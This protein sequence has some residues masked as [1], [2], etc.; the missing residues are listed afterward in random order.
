[1]KNRSSIKRGAWIV[2]L[3]AAVSAFGACHEATYVVDPGWDNRVGPFRLSFSLD[4][5][6]Q[7]THGGH[8]IHIAVVR[9]GVVVAQT[10]GTVSATQNPSFSFAAGA[11]L[12]QGI[13]HEVHYWIDSNIGGGTPGVCDPKAIDHQWS[14]EFSWPTNDVD[15]TVSYQTWLVE[16]VCGTF[17]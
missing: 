6:F 9:G 10:N 5:S 15:I 13:A 3:V 4:A 11:V 1:M 2:T 16:D 17:N 8:P 7:A 14:T 12:E